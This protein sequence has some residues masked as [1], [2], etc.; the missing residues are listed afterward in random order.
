MS[1]KSK[2]VETVQC[3]SI[4]AEP[5][6]EAWGESDEEVTR[7]LAG[8]RVARLISASVDYLQRFVIHDVEIH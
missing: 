3:L 4:Y 5:Q 1:K 8:I 2:T 6:A 7:S